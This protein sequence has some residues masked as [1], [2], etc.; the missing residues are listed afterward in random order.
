MPKVSQK[1]AGVILSYA[2][3]GVYILSA[4]L[5]TPVMLRLLGQSEYGLY[6]LVNSVVSY[7][8]LLSF[9]FSGAYTR[10][11]S[12]Y[13]KDNDENAIARL[14]GLF[15]IIFSFLSAVCILCGIVM[16][17]NITHIFSDGLTS[18]EYAKAKILMMLMVLGVATT[19]VSTVFTCYATVYEKFVFQR[20]LEILQNLLNPFISLPLLIMG[21]GSV[22][23]VIVSTSLVFAKFIVNLTF[24]FKKL[25]IRFSFKNIEK[26]LFK[27]IGVFTSFIFLNQII[28]QVNWSLDKILLGRFCGTTSVAIY[29]VAA[30][31]NLMYKNLL[32]SISSVFVP[33]INMIVAKAKD[34]SN[35]LTDIFT[36]VGRIQF[37]M[38]SLILS[39]FVFFGKTFIKVWA[40]DGYDD[41]F[42]VALLLMI[43]ITVE[44]VQFLGIEIQRAMNMHQARSVIY[45]ITTV[46]N[47]ILS[48]ILIQKYDV[49]G[50]AV[51]TAVSVII[52]EW[53]FINIYYQKK[54][55]LDIIY[56]WKNIFKLIPS[57]IPPVICGILITRFAKIESLLSL[58]VFIL[59]YA[60]I[61]AISVY[62][63]GMNRDEKN[64]VKP[65]FN[66]ILKKLKKQ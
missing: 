56:F 44:L 50:A 45:A 31:L 19:L 64:M 55:K 40:G 2:S 24:C 46:L 47:I 54:I 62:F 65:F 36:K 25:H 58:V 21:K 13:R 14:N 26:K 10:F 6:Q 12:R 4:F 5:Y 16:V 1:K 11:Y 17:K 18:A 30:N 3:Y 8:G 28:D 61:F 29:G 27:E 48:I 20:T 41:S 51:G 35:Q 42:S 60:V 7:L 39:G 33:K 57:V 53:F 15:M 34:V 49:K 63:L 32:S 43:P 38:A 52:G 22:A 9:G 59:I 66:I 23:M 37:M